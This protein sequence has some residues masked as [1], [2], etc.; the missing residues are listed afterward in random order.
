MQVVAELAALPPAERPAGLL[1][2]DS[3][4]GCLPAELGPWVGAARRVMEAG[5]WGCG[6]LLVHAHHGF[7]L[8]QVRLPAAVGW[9]AARCPERLPCALGRR[10]SC[11]WV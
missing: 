2:E 11:M 9:L 3:S 10:S 6:R 7:G 5:G 4:G 1:V 8:A